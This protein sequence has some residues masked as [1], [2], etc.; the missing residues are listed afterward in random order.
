MGTAM[1]THVGL[2]PLWPVVLFVPWFFLGLALLLWP[3]RRRPQPA[4]RARAST[5]L[6]GEE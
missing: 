2:R 3:V 6:L 5:R 1:L 4:Q